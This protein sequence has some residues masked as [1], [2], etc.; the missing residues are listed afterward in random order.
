MMNGENTFFSMELMKEMNWWFV[1][2]IK[3]FL[4]RNLKKLAVDGDFLLRQLPTIPVQEEAQGNRM[5]KFYFLLPFTGILLFMLLVGCAKTRIGKVKL[6][7]E[8]LP[9]FLKVG[10]TRAQEVLE[11]IGEP[12][13]Y[14]E[15]KN[16][17]SIISLNFQEDYVNFLI[18]EIRLERHL[19]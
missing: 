16:R 18:T 8:K 6:S 13:G 14:R 19:G 1:L 10:T 17:S 9:N 5:T 3:S 12:F 2:Q 7:D 4:K 11:Q 15:Q